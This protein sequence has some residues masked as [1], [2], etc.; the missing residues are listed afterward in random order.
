MYWPQKCGKWCYSL[1]FSLTR[2]SGPGQSSSCN[3][4]PYVVCML[5]VECPL[6]MKFI[7]SGCRGDFWSK[8]VFLYWPAM[9]QLKKRSKFVVSPRLLKRAVLD[10][11]TKTNV[12]S[13]QNVFLI[14]LIYMYIM[15]SV[16]LSTSVKRFSVSR[17]QY[18]FW[19]L[20]LFK[21]E[22]FLTRLRKIKA[23]NNFKG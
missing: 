7:T 12:R 2:P 14:I 10:P 20:S 5:N 8:N 4:R 23:D 3:V 22:I 16:L 9:T 13:P 11:P 21:R 19:G 6:R 15:L 1:L 18:F 17:M